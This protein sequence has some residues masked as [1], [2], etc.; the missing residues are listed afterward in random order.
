MKT[1]I[2]RHGRGFSLLEVLVAV[3]ILSIGL[4]ALAALQV[5]LIRSS[6]DAKAQTVA[7]ALAKQKLEDMRSFT[8]IAGYVALTDPAD[9][10][11]SAGGVAFTRHTVVERYA[12]NNVTL[13]YVSI[14][15][16]LAENA[17]TTGGNTLTTG[18]DFK[19]VAVT[20]NWTDATAGA[21]SQAVEDIIDG[22]DPT[23]S[24]KISKNFSGFAPRNAEVVILNPSTEAGVI[25]IAI[26][27]ANAESTAATNPRPVV[28]Q[29]GNETRFDVLTYVALSG[30]NAL[31]QARVETNVS[32]CTCDTANVT[33][34]TGFR[35]SYW[36]GYRYV[37]PTLATYTAP[38]KHATLPN[39]VYESPYCDVCCRDHHDPGTLAAGSP[40]FDPWRNPHTHYG[41]TN[42]GT[43]EA[44]GTS[45]RTEYLEACRLIR[46]DGI[47]RVAADFNDEYFNMLA[48]K[49]DASTT[50]YVP[51][52]NAAAAYQTFVLGYLDA[53]LTS[54]SA[55]NTYNSPVAAGTVTT[56]EGSNSSTAS[57]NYPASI[58]LQRTLDHKWLHS[59]ALYIDWLEA[60]ALAA[61]AATKAECA[62][63]TTCLAAEKSVRVLSLTPFTTINVSE[64][65][66]WAPAATANNVLAVS[67]GS[68]YNEAA[69][70]DSPVRGY[71]TPSASIPTGAQSVNVTASLFKSNS[72]L[73]SLASAIDTDEAT[74]STD[75]TNQTFVIPAGNPNNNAGKLKFYLDVANSGYL[76]N[77][78]QDPSIG[79][80]LSGLSNCAYSIT[81]VSGK[82]KSDN[83]IIC[84]ESTFGGLS[85]VLSGYNGQI[86]A[87]STAQ[88]SCTDSNGQNAVNHTFSSAEA[89]TTYTCR[90]YSV[91]GAYIDANANM[92]F[93][94]GDVNALSFAP[95]LNDGKLAEKSTIAF[96]SIIGT[97]TPPTASI[98]FEMTYVDKIQPLTCKYTATTACNSQGNNCTTTNTYA[99]T[100]S[101]C[102]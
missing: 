48:A 27:P 11:I 88:L 54:N 80:V 42:A 78:I 87:T 73:V 58:T 84:D 70:T 41:L 64:L 61:I 52:D 67:D 79:G 63:S 53:K 26:D 6:A 86:Q 15:D 75:P 9:E 43:L 60:D 10:N 8:S 83:P 29:G 34:T 47:Y 3:V 99:T 57:I 35:P 97:G 25:P 30:N 89:Y 33:A 92:S 65:S 85:F 12:L 74:P 40:K 55:Q 24:S 37:P 81:K 68:F 22:L 100:T 59:R 7:L 5:S 23:D 96:S 20:V 50:E 98:T 18:R 101:T 56:L 1:H 93:D 21:Q 4:L 45:G 90:N 94:A 44:V 31:A 13:A 49:N 69:G 36:N 28:N 16:T 72:G 17:F 71:A 32:A 2:R 91:D 77:F 51:T 14:G 76:T 102:L 95:D 66:L 62:A 82:N 38:A 46:V 19:R 39:K